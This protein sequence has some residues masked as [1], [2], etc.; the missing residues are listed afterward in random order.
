ML[1]HFLLNL[2]FSLFQFFFLNHY[3]LL[4][5]HEFLTKY[6][7]CISL[8]NDFLKLNYNNYLISFHIKIVIFFISNLSS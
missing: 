3:V 2:S 1:F 8:M 4:Y 7:M 6:S 5:F